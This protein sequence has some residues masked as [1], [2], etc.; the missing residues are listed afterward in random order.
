MIDFSSPM[1]NIDHKSQ[2][3]T[4]YND[5]WI[6]VRERGETQ[7]LWLVKP[8]KVLRRG[9]SPALVQL[10][11][12]VAFNPQLTP[13]VLF[14]FYSIIITGIITYIKNSWKIRCNS[15]EH[16]IFTC[17]IPYRIWVARLKLKR[18]DGGKA[19][20]YCTHKRLPVI[21]WRKVGIVDW[22]ENSDW[23]PPQCSW[24]RFRKKES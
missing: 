15:P 21:C 6:R 14:L 16:S 11:S 4:R 12:Y 22:W 20:A 19:G 8:P 18:I 7:V 10:L 23:K 13:L 9:R 2:S 24:M 3:K 17:F 1:L 5:Q